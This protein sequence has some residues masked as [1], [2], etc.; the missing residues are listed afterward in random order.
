M[1]DESEGPIDQ[2]GLSGSSPDDEEPRGRLQEV[3]QARRESLARL[4]E[5]GV[6]PFALRFTRDADAHELRERY[7]GLGTGEETEDR[8]SVAGRIV[9]LRRQG[10]LS[11]ATLRD[12]TA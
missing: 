11:F 10:K 9:L 6:E 7:A 4:R 8:R 2:G 3:L 5:R 1:S 12:G